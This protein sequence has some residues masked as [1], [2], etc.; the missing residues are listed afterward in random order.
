MYDDDE[1]GDEED[2]DEISEAQVAEDDRRVAAEGTRGIEERAFYD[3]LAKREDEKHNALRK[4]KQ[5]RTLLVGEA[6]QKL[7]HKE[8]EVTALAQ[9]I[10]IEEDRMAL[11]KKR[12]YRKNAKDIVDGVVVEEPVRAEPEVIPILSRDIAPNDMDEEFSIERAEIHIKQL[13]E[14][15]AELEKVVAEMKM[16][17]NEDERALSQIEHQIMRM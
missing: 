1:F 15:K 16:K 14:Q 5:R 8:A 10:H 4:D 3:D 7:R 6:R 9:K 11:E 12:L 2:D 13:G 17:L